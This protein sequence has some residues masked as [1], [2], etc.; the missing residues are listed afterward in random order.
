[1][2]RNFLITK[3]I[4]CRLFMSHKMLLNTEAKAVGRF[5]SLPKCVKC[6]F[7]RFI[8]HFKRDGL[9]MTELQRKN[10]KKN[11]C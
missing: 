2:V 1:M 4:L 10:Y 3:I 6:N 7:H 8:V 9:E 11:Y 5:I